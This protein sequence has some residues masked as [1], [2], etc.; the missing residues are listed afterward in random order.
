MALI[1]M[2]FL[3]SL[4]RALRLRRGYVTVQAFCEAQ[5][6]RRTRYAEIEEGFWVP[7]SVSTLKR[8]ACALGTGPGSDVWP[9]I[10][11]I[12]IVDR[13]RQDPARAGLSFHEALEELTGGTPAKLDADLV[14]T[15]LRRSGQRPGGPSEMPPLKR[16]LP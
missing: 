11:G 6:L 14:E 4:F 15:L 10:R 7:S 1:S 5:G 13:Y 8:F 2:P 16:K 12:W 9:E 3:R